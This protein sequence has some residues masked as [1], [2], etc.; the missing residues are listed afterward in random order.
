MIAK[1]FSLC[2]FMLIL[3]S[4]GLRQREQQLEQ[5][6]TK[7]DEKEQQL[8]LQEKKLQL[9]EEELERREKKL[10]SLAIF[11]GQ[12]TSAAIDPSLEGTWSARMRCVETNCAGSA[13]GD[14]R[15]E[16]WLFSYEN[17]SI[18]VKAYSGN[19]LVRIYSGDIAFDPLQLNAQLDADAQTTRMSVRL[20]RIR[21]NE[22]KGERE[23]VRSD[24]CTILYALELKKH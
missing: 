7:L 18:L 12:D 15:N 14:T 2:M 16:Q 5:R 20:N 8:T 24:G 21:Q 9:K 6:S 17:N 22:L 3:G 10:D 23:I 19:K 4:C 13:V 11:S 1:I